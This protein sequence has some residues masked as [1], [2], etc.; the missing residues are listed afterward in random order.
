LELANDFRTAPIHVSVFGDE[1]AKSKTMHGLK[2]A[3]G[4]IQK[5]IAGQ[6]K[7]RTTPH[8]TLELDESIE[9]TF[10]SWRR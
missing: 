1:G 8:V 3:R 4:L 6:M 10:P 7:T 2:D 5:R 9:K